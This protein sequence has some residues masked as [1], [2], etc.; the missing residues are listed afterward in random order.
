VAIRLRE[1][2]REICK[3]MD[4]EIIKG[5]ISKDH[6]HMLPPCVRI[7]HQNFFKLKFDTKISYILYK[8]YFIITQITFGTTGC[9]YWLDLLD[10]W[11][12]GH[13]H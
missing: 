3:T 10:R 11:R 12:Y 9:F 4:I 6:V 5:H 8:Q 1:I 13:S 2:I 7:E